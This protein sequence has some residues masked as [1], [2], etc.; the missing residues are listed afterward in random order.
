MLCDCTST[1]RVSLAPRQSQGSPSV[2]EP[3]QGIQSLE[4]V[5][6]RGGVNVLLIGESERGCWQ[7]ARRLEERGCRWW[8]ASTTDDVRSLLEER[9]FHLVLSTCPVARG[10]AIMELLQGSPC[11]V[12]YSYPIEDSCLWLQAAY[13]GRACS[14]APVLRP[15]EFASALDEMVTELSVMTT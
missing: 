1:V 8:F 6:E 9:P 5:M 3:V 12:F 4:G 14:K 2:H 7:L 10:S 11:N 15:S 13:Q